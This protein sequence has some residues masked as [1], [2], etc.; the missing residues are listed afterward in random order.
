MKVTSN[1]KKGSIMPCMCWYTPNEEDK[2]HFKHICSQL[3]DYIKHLERHGDPLCCTLKD[4]HEL[5][6]HLY[7][8]S[9]CQESEKND[10]I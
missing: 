9:Q 4:A 1:V 3:V 6:D 2:I 5:I 8:P 7:D 10:N